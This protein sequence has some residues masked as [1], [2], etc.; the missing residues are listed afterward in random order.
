VIVSV[1]E[2]T[3]PVGIKGVGEKLH[4]APTGRPKQLNETA[5]A[6]PFCGATSTVAVPLCPAGMVSEAGETAIE[7]AGADLST[8]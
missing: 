7:N 3:A 8:T 5:D 2:V 1:A 4:D 6:K